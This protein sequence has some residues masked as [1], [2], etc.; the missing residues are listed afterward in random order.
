V[1]RPPLNSTTP[2]LRTTCWRF[3]PTLVPGVK[4]HI[5]PPSGSTLLEPAGSP[6]RARSSGHEDEL[7][8]FLEPGMVERVA[9]EAFALDPA[10]VPI[11]PLDGLQW[12]GKSDG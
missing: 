2:Y 4:R 5:P 10:R 12:G 1:R 7:H 11:A 8:I 6:V 3:L 9:A